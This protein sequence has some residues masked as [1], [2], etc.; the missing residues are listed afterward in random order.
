MVPFR[1]QLDNTCNEYGGCLFRQ[2][3]MSKE[4]EPWLEANFQKR[5]WNP[6]TREEEVVE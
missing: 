6:L 5:R 1:K 4:P 3:C 2:I